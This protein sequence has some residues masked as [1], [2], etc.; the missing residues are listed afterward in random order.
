MGFARAHVCDASLVAL[1]HHTPEIRPTT[2][3]LS[4]RRLP[5][6]TACDDS[7][8][9]KPPK[10]PPKT[11]K[12][13]KP[14][15]RR[16]PPISRVTIA[17]WTFS[18]ISTAGIVLGLTVKENHVNAWHSVHAWGAVAIAAAVVTAAPALSGTPHLSP[19]RAWQIAAAGAGV[20]VFFWILFV[21]PRVGSNTSLLATIGVAAGV[22]AAWLAPGRHAPPDAGG[23]H[24]ASTW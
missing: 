12:P 7:Q 14:A 9:T 4:D 5:A 1:P 23:A 6:T 17:I 13:P 10:T 20:L 2:Y 18:A 15:K 8:V 21:L 11:A 22:A 16:R 3:R 24:S 19:V